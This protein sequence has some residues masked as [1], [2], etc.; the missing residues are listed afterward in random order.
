MYVINFIASPCAGKSLM[1]S[2]LFAELK[3][4]HL[5]AEYVQEHAKKLI[6]EEKFDEL[7]NQFNI[8]KAQYDVI[9]AVSKKV[10]YTI[11]D[12]GII[13]NLFYNRHYTN[14]V[15]DIAKVE[16]IFKEKL[17]EFNNINIFLER[18]EEYPYEN[19]GRV[20]TQEQSKQIEVEM[21]EMLK[22]FSQE[23]LKIKSHKDSIPK[24]IEYIFETEKTFL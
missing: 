2:L 20:H 19:E 17:N 15:C 14:N 16:K 9:K 12:S 4:M 21:E 6:Y 8:S 11:C 23:Y 24:I 18:N 1:S 10:K 7:N 13:V 3:M 5:N 22:E